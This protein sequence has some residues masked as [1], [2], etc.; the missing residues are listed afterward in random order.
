M[1]G[2][3]DGYIFKTKKQW[4]D[5]TG[6]SENQITRYTQKFKVRGFL[7]T[8]LMKAYGNPTVHY[9]LDFEK[10]SDLFRVFLI[11]RYEE[12]QRNESLKSIESLTENT[13][14]NTHDTTTKERGTLTS[15]SKGDWED[16]SSEGEYVSKELSTTEVD[17]SSAESAASPATKILIPNDF[18][19]T[20]DAKF[21]AALAFPNKS[22]SFA[23]EKFIR[24]FNLKGQKKIVADWHDEWWN[25]MHTERPSYDNDSMEAELSEIKDK[26][27][28]DIWALQESLPYVFHFTQVIS[29][30]DTV[31][32]SEETLAEGLKILVQTDNLAE[33]GGYYFNLHEYTENEDWKKRIDGDL[34]RCGLSY[35]DGNH[36]DKVVPSTGEHFRDIFNDTFTHG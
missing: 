1:G 25:W 21:R 36:S 7:D 24:H 34:D 33:V 8:K 6:L 27:L 18:R 12:N 14:K 19:P 31:G 4:K 28:N 35:P 20:L 10:L 11:N 23:T 15:S 9:K 3:Q 5:E 16:L 32:F 17:K 22:Q 26:V 13:S 2:L 30:A 29:Q